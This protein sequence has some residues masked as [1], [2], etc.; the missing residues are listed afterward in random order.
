MKQQSFALL[1]ALFLSI[2]C[3][4]VKEESKEEKPKQE[5]KSTLPRATMVKKD[6]LSTAEAVKLAEAQFGKYLPKMLEANNAYPDSQDTFTGDF[7]GDG[8]ADI[9]IYFSLA[10]KEGGN[11]IVAQGL[12]LYQNNGT[13]VKVIAGFEPNYLFSFTKIEKGKI[14]I[15]KLAYADTDGRCCPS[16]KTD[17]ILTIAGNTVY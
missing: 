4:N 7:T 10:P 6:S 11:T 1:F 14:Y 5:S 17:H 3:N 16:I 12:A 9:A 8:I 13:T 15:E 2:G